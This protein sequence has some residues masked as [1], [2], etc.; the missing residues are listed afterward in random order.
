MSVVELGVW[1]IVS[2][3]VLAV[4]PG[5]AGCAEGKDM[6][7]RGSDGTRVWEHGGG[8]NEF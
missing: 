8:V 5:R 7:L 6:L 2:P 4:F 3:Y 1:G